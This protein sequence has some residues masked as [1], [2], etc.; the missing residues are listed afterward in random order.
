MNG[1]GGEGGGREV[2]GGEGGQA[3]R[4]GELFWAGAE[5]RRVEK[6][7][8]LARCNLELR[9]SVTA[10]AGGAPLRSRVAASCQVRVARDAGNQHTVLHYDRH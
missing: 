8:E 6:N 3:G 10:R 9:L 2:G 5:G 7:L 1:G 4:L